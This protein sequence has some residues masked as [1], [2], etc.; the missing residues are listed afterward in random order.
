[1]KIYSYL[2]SGVPI[3]ATDIESHTQ[4]L[5][6]EV[7]V[8]SAATATSFAEGIAR[9]IANPKHRRNLAANAGRL[10]EERYSREAF[11]QK[12]RKF[13]DAVVAHLDTKP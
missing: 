13:Y 7:S 9:L 1:M 2:A 11:R 8:L 3:V 12:V 4:V 6:P 10:V 5:T